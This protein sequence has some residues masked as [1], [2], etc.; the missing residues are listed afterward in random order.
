[1][2]ASGI[3]ACEIGISDN[4]LKIDKTVRLMEM[5]FEM[6]HKVENVKTENGKR[7]ISLKIGI[8]RGPCIATVIGHHKPQ[9]SLIGDTVNTTSRV[10]ANVKKEVLISAEAY[11]SILESENSI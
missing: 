4:I 10:T 3:K 9:F 11:Q 2:A 5:A 7:T 6:K 1:M 8:H